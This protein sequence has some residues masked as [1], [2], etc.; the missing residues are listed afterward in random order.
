MKK[1]LTL[2][3]A[4]VLVLSFTGCKSGIKLEEGQM[5]ITFKGDEVTI[6]AVMEDD[7]LEDEYDVDFKDD[8]NKEIAE[9]IVDYFDDDDIDV[10]AKV[11]KSGKTATVTI[12]FEDA[13]DAYMELDDTVEDVAD[14]YGYDDIEDYFDDFDI[15]METVKD[16]DKVKAKEME[17]YADDYMLMVFGGDEGIYYTFDSTVLLASKSMDFEYKSKT[18]IFIED[19]ESGYLVVKEK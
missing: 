6:V 13:E 16:G 3:L 18:T 4:I 1:L 5:H 2:A 12:V 8:S 7:D 11:K 14:D 10:T 17:D 15:T 9:E 19:D